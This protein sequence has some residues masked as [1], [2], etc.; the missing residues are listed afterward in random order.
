MRRGKYRITLR[1]A[2]GHIFV[3]VTRAGA[4]TGAPTG[5]SY[6]AC[7]LNPNLSGGGFLRGLGAVQMGDCG[8]EDSFAPD[9]AFAGV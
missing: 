3:G 6:S 2:N 4:A 8:G 1:E 5:E 9:L 7:R